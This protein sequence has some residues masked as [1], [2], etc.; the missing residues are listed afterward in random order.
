MD[1]TNRLLRLQS[2]SRFSE[3]IELS[4]VERK[5]IAVSSPFPFRKRWSW[6]CTQAQMANYLAEKSG[7]SKKQ[8]KVTL[9][10]PKGPA[11]NVPIRWL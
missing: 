11:K 10:Q 5:G 2:H 9:D 1:A 7:L 6:M 8:A 4:V 3:T